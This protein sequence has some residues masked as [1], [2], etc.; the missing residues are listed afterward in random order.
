WRARDR[1]RHG[2][3]DALVPHSARRGL[4]A[5]LLGLRQEQ[6]RRIAAPNPARTGRAEVRR[7]RR[8][9]VRQ[10]GKIEL[11]EGRELEEDEPMH[12]RTAVM[13]LIA[14]AALS[15]CSGYMAA[16]PYGGGGG[17]GGGGGGG[18]GG[19]VGSVAVGTNGRIVF[20]SAHN[21]T[22]NPAVDTV[23]GGSTVTWTGTHNQGRA[24][25]DK[26]QGSSVQDLA[27]L[28]SQPVG[29]EG[30]LQEGE[31]GLEQSLVHD[32]RVWIAGHVQHF[33]FRAGGLEQQREFVAVHARHDDVRH[34]QVDLPLVALGHL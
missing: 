30:L 31:P 34:Q 29:P 9:P 12:V 25:S 20:T 21:R 16:G 22:V 14:L 5:R 26:A 7:T 33:H 3:R 8:V 4:R 28:P 19:P 6:D 1:Q 17:D 23:A 15:G 2:A 27:H 13:S 32:R 24:P 10:L 11:R 18:G